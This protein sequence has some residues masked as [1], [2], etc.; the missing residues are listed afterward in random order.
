MSVSVCVSP[1]TTVG[2]V[3]MF[4]FGVGA[5]KWRLGHVGAGTGWRGDA[6]TASVLLAEGV[7]L[8]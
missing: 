7:G 3:V 4:G 6:A 8:R 5:Q 2:H 1:S